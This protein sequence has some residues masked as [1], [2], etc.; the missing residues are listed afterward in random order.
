MA[1]SRFA[2]TLAMETHA[3]SIEYLAA[4]ECWAYLSRA[5]LGRLAV[6]AHD[7]VDIF[8]V[9]FLSD[10]ASLFLRSAP[11]EK[12][13]AITANPLVAFEVDGEED[14]ARWSVVLKGTAARLDSDL[15]I[16][17]SGVLGLYT[18]SPTQ[19]WNYVQVSPAVVTGRRFREV[20]RIP[21]PVRESRVEVTR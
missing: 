16:E 14:G 21:D 17:E 10:G 6:L 11:G 13:V 2:K 9:N 7:G 15:E 19:K 1:R 3:G 4:D 18:L 8:P 12:L 20:P 5:S